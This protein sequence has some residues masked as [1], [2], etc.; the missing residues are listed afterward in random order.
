MASIKPPPGVNFLLPAPKEEEDGPRIE[1]ITDDLDDVML[2]EGRSTG[3]G[4]LRLEGNDDAD[5][6]DDD[7]D[8]G[9][10]I[11]TNPDD[12]DDDDDDGPRIEENPDDDDDDD[13]PAMEANDDPR[14]AAPSLIAPML[15]D[16]DDDDDD[17]DDD[18]SYVPDDPTE[19]EE[20]TDHEAEQ[21]AFQL[22]D[23]KFVPQGTELT[24]PPR[25][26]I[27]VTEEG[28][29]HKKD[30]FEPMS[31]GMQRVHY[32]SEPEPIWVQTKTARWIQSASEINV[33]PYTVCSRPVTAL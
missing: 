14:Q 28:K 20:E 19:S 13:G 2:D 15:E 1:D 8:D 21:E 23:S 9:P 26:Y 18:S 11:E 30:K 3:G 24:L 12:D 10:R 6:E 7:D 16:N 4:G 33:I 27:L 5:D 29:L 25:N 32:E 22:D 17:D 31:F